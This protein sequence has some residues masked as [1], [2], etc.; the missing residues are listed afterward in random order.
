MN[1]IFW[2]TRFSA[3]E[4]IYGT[5]PNVFFKQEINKLQP[6]KILLPA[7]G[8]G[9][10]AVYAAK[11]G[12][13]VFA[14][15]FSSQAKIKA[16]KLAENNNVKIKYITTDFENAHF[17]ENFFDCIGLFYAHQNSN[18]REK[19]HKKLLTYLKQGGKLILE[20]FSKQQ[21]GKTSGG[22]DSME[23]LYSKKDLE[24]DFSILKNLI[25]EE[26]NTI[27]HEGKHKGTASIIN[28]TGE[29]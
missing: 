8:E 10:N 6:G 9:R 25:I 2:D 20:A 15:D 23:M 26:K 5:E 27:L 19:Y 18:V 22:P 28:L 7:E 14:F 24:K 21:L 13:D 4:Y 29:K 3:N 16:E 17:P 1:N 11:K 12:W